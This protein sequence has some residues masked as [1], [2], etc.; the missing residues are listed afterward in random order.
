MGRYFTVHPGE[1]FTARVV[2]FVRQNIQSDNPLALADVTVWVP[3]PRIAAAVKD[4]FL[5]E[6]KGVILPQ[7]RSFSVGE[8][9]SDLL[10]F[11]MEEQQ[12][13]SRISPLLK[14]LK[15]AQWVHLKEK[16]NYL[17]L[18]YFDIH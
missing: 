13:T 17:L 5:K 12:T 6:H 18:Y 9:D 7:I 16:R 8:E 14:M 2:D 10:R 11:E 1:N 3:A 15:L 4:A